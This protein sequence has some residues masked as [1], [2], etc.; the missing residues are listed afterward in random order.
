MVFPPHFL[1]HRYAR[2]GQEKGTW[3]GL[4]FIEADERFFE[5]PAVDWL[6]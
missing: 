3:C 1:Q 5:V 2:P 4:D 6:I